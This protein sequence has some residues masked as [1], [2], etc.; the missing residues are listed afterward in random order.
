MPEDNNNPRQ[1]SSHGERDVFE[2]RIA[3][4]LD[5]ETPDKPKGLPLH[6]KILIGLAVGVI[7]GVAVN[8]LMG[9]D[10]PRVVGI[11]DNITKPVGQLF[12]RLLLMIVVP[13]VLYRIAVNH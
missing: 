1:T 7:A 5:E 6:T 12:L 10:H 13:L 8:Q 11:V 9:G 2:R 3:T 4:D